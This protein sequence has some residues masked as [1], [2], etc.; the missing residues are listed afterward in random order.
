MAIVSVLPLSLGGVQVPT[1]LLGALFSNPTD[2]KNLLYPIDLATNP[3]YCHAVRFSI[4]D[5]TTGISENPEKIV[6][7]VKNLVTDLA[8]PTK[9]NLYEFFTTI[10]TSGVS[11]MDAGISMVESFATVL[12]ASS[13][14]MVKQGAPLATIS[15]F[16]PDTLNTSFDSNWS[17]IS[18][19][20]TLGIAGYLGNAYA[21]TKFENRSAEDIAAQTYK[22]GYTTQL[23]IAALGLAGKAVG[24]N[25]S[26][27]TSALGTALK[28][29]PNP[30]MQ[31]IYKGIQLRE[32]QLDFLFTP[33][34]AQEADSVEK[35][36]NSFIYYSVPDYT[37]GPSGQFLTPPQIFNIKFAF[38]GDSG[39]LS[40]IENVLTSTLTNVLG[41]QLTGAVFGGN[42]TAKI[43]A[44]KKA[45]VFEFGDCVLKNV[46][47]DYAPNG[48]A[49]Y[50]DGNPIQ[51]RM[52]LQ[53]QEMDIVT[54]SSLDYQQRGFGKS[55]GG[56]ALKYGTNINSEQTAMLAAQDQ[57]LQ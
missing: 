21:D 19:T 55:T 35:I 43:T 16:M 28:Q 46:L 4:F 37:G 22:N 6:T 18:M 9:S 11:P 36:I 24:I 1:N 2:S 52:T 5:Y 14:K 34:S 3:T 25:S 40:S 32:F 31:L 30:Q 47:V 33:V 44:A 53:F 15:L 54:K 13:Y 48:W 7:Q 29:V 42:P 23:G 38:T 39:V 57:G 12:Q 10:G 26:G 27:L 50:N 20:D 17:S 56:T 41:S 45:K 49:S 8:N 51:S